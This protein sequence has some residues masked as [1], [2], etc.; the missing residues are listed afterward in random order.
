MSVTDPMSRIVKQVR[1]HMETELG[2]GVDALA[3][4]SP[5]PVTTESAPQAPPLSTLTPVTAEEK[6][7]AL[8]ALAAEMAS[9]S[10]CPLGNTRTKLVFGDGSPSAR[11]MFVGE[12]PGHDEDMQGKPFVG[13]A[14]QLLTRIIIAMGLRR[15]D[16]YIANILKCR[17]PENRQPR[18][19]EVVHCLPFLKRQIHI[20]QPELIICLGGV[21]AQ[22]LLETVDGITRLRGRFLDYE[23]TKMLCTYHPAYLLRNPDAK[24]DV[25]GDMQKALT[26]LGLPVPKH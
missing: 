20:I 17:P 9:C 12:A 16:V 22:T 21:A 11:I 23:S 15:E 8:D 7:A 24:G 13:R 1:Q 25:W 5:P 2:F 4:V 3:K 10:R 18:P 6:R 14:G 19:S 26:F